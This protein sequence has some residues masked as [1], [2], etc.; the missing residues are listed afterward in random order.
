MAGLFVL[1]LYPILSRLKLKEGIVTS[2]VIM[3]HIFNEQRYGFDLIV[4]E[5]ALLLVGLGTATLINIVYM[6]KA[7]KQL[8]DL[9]QTGKLFFSYFF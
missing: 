1:I 8:S 9:Y 4:N 6:P 5:I 2:S 3:F 7:D